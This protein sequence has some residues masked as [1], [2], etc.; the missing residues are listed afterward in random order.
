MLSPWTM[1]KILSFGK[2]LKRGIYSHSSSINNRVQFMKNI[3]FFSAF[4]L[5]VTSTYCSILRMNSKPFPK[6][7]LVFTC[8]RYKSF[9]NTGKRE[10]LLVTSNFSFSHSIFYWFGELSTTFIKFEIVVCN[11]FQ[12]GRV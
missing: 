8:L 10:K 7:S 5:C 2:K 12:F 3:L 4:L 9:E 1:L 11:L 6:Q